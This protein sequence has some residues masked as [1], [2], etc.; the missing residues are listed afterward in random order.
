MT[1]TIPTT[2]GTRPAS[3]V[4]KP[5]ALQV[6]RRAEVDAPAIPAV[7]RPTSPQLP[8]VP[9]TASAAPPGLLSPEQSAALA[10]PLNRANVQTR[11][12]AGRSLNYLEGWV[13]IKEANRIFGFD[14]WQRETI[15]LRCVAESQRPIGREQKPGWGVTYI[16]RVR[17][18][19]GNQANGAQSLVREGSGAGHGID[20][21]LGLAHES[22]LKEAETDA[23]K[24]ALMTF[25]N[26]FGL[27]LYDK[28]QRQVTSSVREERGPQGQGPLVQAGHPH[29]VGETRAIRPE[30]QALA[31]AQSPA[32]TSDAALA[33]LTPEVIQQL[34]GAIRGLPRPQ[35]EA[36][37]IA[38]RQRF[39]L[40]EGASVAAA[41]TQKQHHDWVEAY[42]VQVEGR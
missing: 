29:P 40:S 36:L 15:E 2:N 32:A 28:Q 19:L 1:S 23:M 5:S 14:G 9:A 38:F 6:L 3:L 10:A 16:A 42:L 31:P 34:H 18:R 33:A 20:V 27:A 12:Q 4:Q 21:D 26:P 41:I 25:G 8:D 13:A 37:V 17:I 22:A 24:R 7:N 35:L 30:V 39:R 11:S